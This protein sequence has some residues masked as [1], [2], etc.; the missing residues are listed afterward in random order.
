MNLTALV[1]EYAKFNHWANQRYVHW[2]EGLSDELLTKEMPSS[3]PSLRLTFLHIWGAETI[4]LSRLQGVSPTVFL[5]TTFKGSNAELFEGFMAN[6]ADF[7]NFIL[8]Q[9]DEYFTGTLAYT[10]TSGAEYN[11][12]TAEI[13]LHCIQHSTFHRGQ[14]LTMAR[15][16]GQTDP[17]ATDFIGYVRQRNAQMIK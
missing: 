13:I 14:I 4:W 8:A 12:N 6:T 17:P 7:R 3:F 16:L 15:S 2:L 10:H 11:E 9:P 5:A 1:K